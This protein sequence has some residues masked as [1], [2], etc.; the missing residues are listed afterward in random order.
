[1]EISSRECRNCDLDVHPFQA[2]KG[3][4]LGNTNLDAHFSSGKSLED[5]ELTSTSS[6][7]KG[8]V[9]LSSLRTKRLFKPVPRN[10]LEDQVLTSIS[11]LSQGMF[12]RIK[13]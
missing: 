10:G 8:I 9:S 5:L 6:L 3:E 13:H 2:G 4:G 1:M 7:S 12:L 11:T